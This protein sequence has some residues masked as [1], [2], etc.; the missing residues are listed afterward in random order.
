MPRLE[1]CLRELTSGDD[2]RA[3]KAVQD[4]SILKTAALPALLDL[5]QSNDADHRWG[6]TAAIS[7]IKDVRSQDALCKALRDED[8][9]V[10]QS[11][12]LGLKDQPA[13]KAIP[14]L[15]ELLGSHD[16][17][18]ARL[19]SNALT[20]LAGEAVSPL[21]IALREENPQVRIEAARALSR[22]QDAA[23][24]PTL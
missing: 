1:D 24:I 12:A 17:G 9:A 16:R 4:L 13:P 19:A 3:E 21:T 22:I 6:A 8:E 11:A 2:R 23:A 10:Q 14:A 20:S 7:R 5:Q 15:V 18:L